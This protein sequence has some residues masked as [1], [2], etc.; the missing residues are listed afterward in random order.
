M[1]CVKAVIGMVYN[2]ILDQ[3]YSA[4]PGNG[5]FLNGSKLRVTDVKGELRGCDS[6]FSIIYFMFS[7]TYSPITS[8]VLLLL[9]HKMEAF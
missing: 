7:L 1:F 9:S 6:N 3:M 5:A 2:P 8:Y 4:R